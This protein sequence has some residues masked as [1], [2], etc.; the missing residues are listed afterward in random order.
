MAS[1]IE[2]LRASYSRITAPDTARVRFHAVAAAALVLGFLLGVGLM[3][4]TAPASGGSPHT[5]RSGPAAS[6]TAAG[7]CLRA[8][9]SAQ[10]AMSAAEQAARA[11]GRLETARLQRLLDELQTRQD[12]FDGLAVQ[13]R[14]QARAAG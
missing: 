12:E 5:S 2:V 8:L 6:S 3:W 10:E 13:C 9:T 11:L 7:S 1:P 4:V 14:D